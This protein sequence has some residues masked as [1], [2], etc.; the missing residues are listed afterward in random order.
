[1]D[2]LKIASGTRV[3]RTARQRR[4]GHRSRTFLKT[5][6][7]VANLAIWI[8]RFPLGCSLIRIR[9]AASLS[10]ATRCRGVRRVRRCCK[11]SFQDVSTFFLPQRLENSKS[12]DGLV[13]SSRRARLWGKGRSRFALW[14]SAMVAVCLG[15]ANGLT[16]GR[17]LIR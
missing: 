5:R 9:R 10:R 2:M 13:R 8:T 6:V 17:K 3:A 4:R 12:I 15:V 11:R 14:V 1:M 7:P 16:G